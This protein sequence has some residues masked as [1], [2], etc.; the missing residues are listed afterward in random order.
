MEAIKVKKGKKGKKGGGFPR[1]ADA[2]LFKNMPH[3]FGRRKPEEKEET[4][5]GKK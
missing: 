3:I 1:G 4:K 2:W 5:K